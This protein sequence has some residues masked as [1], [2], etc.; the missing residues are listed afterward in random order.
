MDSSEADGLV[1]LPLEVKGN[2]LLP[3]GV[4]VSDGVGHYLFKNFF[5]ILVPLS[6]LHK[7]ATPPGVTSL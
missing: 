6:F 3:Q 1:A 4:G 2:G 5:E 7:K